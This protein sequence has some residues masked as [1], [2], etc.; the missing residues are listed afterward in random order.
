M[1]G[2]TD[3]LPADAITHA[4]RKDLGDI[5]RD[6]LLVPVNPC[7]IADTQRR[8]GVIAAGTVRHFDVTLTGSYAHQGGASGTCNGVGTAGAFGAA[9]ITVTAVSPL[10][11]GH[12]AVFPLGNTPPV[13][14]ALPF[15]AGVSTSTTLH[16][17]L[18]QS[19]ALAELSIAASASTHVT[20]DIVG[21][22]RPT[23]PSPM[24]LS[25]QTTAEATANVNA[26]ATAN[27]NAPACTAPRVSVSTNCES[28]TWQMPFVYIAS[29]TCSAQNNSAGTATLRASRVCCT[30][31]G[32]LIGQNVPH[33]APQPGPDAALH[34]GQ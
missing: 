7:R 9:L 18:D 17:K 27:L 12:L 25:C 21:Y 33:H 30:P 16:V 11:T 32:F 34:E 1:S 3:L 5:D 19:S 2:R 4:S 28:S 14:D 20:L 24:A 8:G 15:S 10:G 29:G 31:A 23:R 6:L 13:A 22:F 26:G